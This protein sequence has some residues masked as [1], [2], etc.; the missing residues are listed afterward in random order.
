MNFDLPHLGEGVQEAE[1][2]RWLV[3]PGDTVKPGDILL[4]AL[5]D[6][7]TMEVP[8]PFAGTVTGLI[9]QPGQPVKVGDV[10][11]SYT[12]GGSEA[13]AAPAPAEVATTKKAAAAIAKAPLP[14]S[15]TAAPTGNGVT[16][17]PT[18]AVKAAPSVRHLARKLGIDLCRVDH[19]RAFVAYWAVPVES[20]TAAVGSWRRGVPT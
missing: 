13:D 14:E 6:K 19:F 20:E 5:T 8:S 9:A 17:R 3:K 2:V 12:G 16:P 1:L 10:I 15:V 18:G 4:E 11:L 7:A